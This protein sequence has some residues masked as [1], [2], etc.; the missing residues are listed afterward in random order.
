MAVQ[1]IRETQINQATQ[2]TLT[3]LQFLNATSILKLPTGDSSTRPGTPAFG[4]IRYNSEIDKAEIYVQDFD[5]DGNNGWAEVGS[6][7]GLSLGSDS[8][9]RA[10][11]ATIAE[12]IDIPAVAV[13]PLYE[14]CF[15]VGPSMTITTGNSVSIGA[16]ANWTII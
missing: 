7:G 10:N 2:A 3:T 5:G 8:V 14:N 1:L 16:G 9:I 4:Y 11:P 12:V 13:D 6:G 15:S